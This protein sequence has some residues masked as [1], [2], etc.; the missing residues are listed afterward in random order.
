MFGKDKSQII[1][2]QEDLLKM[3][4]QTFRSLLTIT[5]ELLTESIMDFE[6]GVPKEKSKE[7]A[8]SYV[9]EHHAEIVQRFNDAHSCYSDILK[10]YH[11]L[12]SSAPTD[13]KKVNTNF[14]LQYV[15]DINEIIEYL[16][17]LRPFILTFRVRS[18]VWPKSDVFAYTKA[19]VEAI[20]RKD[21]IEKSDG[22]ANKVSDD[23]PSELVPRLSDGYVSQYMPN[24]E[25][26]NRCW[27]T[28]PKTSPQTVLY[29]I[30]LGDYIGQPYEA[31]L[32][33]SGYDINAPYDV[34]AN[35]F[36]DDSVMALAI[37]EACERIKTMEAVTLKEHGVIAKSYDL[38][39]K[40]MRYYA[41]ML[42]MVGYGPRFYMWAVHDAND[43]NS[44][45]NGGA[46]RA[47]TIGAFFNSV[48]DVIR[49]AIVSS[50]A[51]HSH[52]VGE[53]ATV[54]TAVCVW[55]ANHGATKEEIRDY[56]MSLSSEI[57]KSKDDLD[58]TPEKI[59]DL[60]LRPDDLSS[61]S[62]DKQKIYTLLGTRTVSQALINFFDS[63]D[64]LGCVSNAMKYRCDSDTVAA[65]SGGIA[66][67]YYGEV[68]FMSQILESRFDEK[69]H[70]DNRFIMRRLSELNHN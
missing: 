32:D 43:Y 14:Y 6:T 44:W 36:T 48:E 37:Y 22:F 19:E 26:A 2:L 20:V 3:N 27:N 56:V 45:A 68:P 63:E 4:F 13:A 31:L 61:L 66:A 12:Y 29:G 55:L 30:C 52:P 5:D 62:D 64:V 8:D 42:P 70:S 18:A 54:F 65:I 24:V 16:E 23:L 10:S 15:S 34:Y 11:H 69:V 39:V 51:T 67:A 35:S 25:L 57:I 28:A 9:R 53:K 60:S 1:S 40:S 33:S 7:R 47:G 59:F 49:Y 50:F 58:E 46:M 41:N 21:C 38:F 17:E